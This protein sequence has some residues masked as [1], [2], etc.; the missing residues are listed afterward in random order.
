M[1]NPEL[2]RLIEAA[3]AEVDEEARMTLWQQAEREMF[4]NQ[5]YTFLF[6]RNS[7]TFLDARIAG[8][9][10]TALGLNLM[11]VPVEIWVPAAQQRH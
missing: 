7:L 1:R 9:E 8:L 2:D 4:E 5:P 10:N 3:R 11:S 6:R